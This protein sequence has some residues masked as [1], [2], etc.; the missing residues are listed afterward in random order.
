MTKQLKEEVQER[1]MPQLEKEGLTDLWDKIATE[2]E[3]EMPDQLVEY[4]SKVSHPALEMESL[5]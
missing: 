4:L 1:M 5:F 3:A 2:E